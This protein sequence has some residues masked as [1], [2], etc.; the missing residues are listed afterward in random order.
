MY[1]YIVYM[2]Y[3]LY[4]CNILY[5]QYLCIFIICVFLIPACQARDDG[6]AQRVVGR[7]RRPTCWALRQL[8]RYG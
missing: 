8:D 6:V 5:I 3:I 7:R 2:Q 1:I 4:I